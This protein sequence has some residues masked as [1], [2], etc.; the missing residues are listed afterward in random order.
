MKLIF[1]MILSVF[2]ITACSSTHHQADAN[3]GTASEQQQAASMPEHA[4]G[5]PV[6]PPHQGGMPPG[7]LGM[8]VAPPHQGG[9]PPGAVGM[10]AQPPSMNACV[11]VSGEAALNRAY[12]ANEGSSQCVVDEVVPV[13]PQRVYEV[14][15][16]CEGSQQKVVTVRTKATSNGCRVLGH[17]ALN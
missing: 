2:T 8:P 12:E 15:V 6:A 17:P 9:M 1:A 13:T 5:R 3:R 4:L 7:A 11:R 16:S 10:P 14:T